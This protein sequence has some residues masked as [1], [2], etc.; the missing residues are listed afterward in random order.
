MLLGMRKIEYCRHKLSLDFEEEA[1]F[2][3]LRASL[4]VRSM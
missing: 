3:H 2:M 1:L 4:P